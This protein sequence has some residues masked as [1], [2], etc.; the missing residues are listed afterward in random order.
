MTEDEDQEESSELA[1]I[2]STELIAEIKRERA[3]P[4]SVYPKVFGIAA[5]T[6]DA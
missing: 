2:Y 6:D 3:N 5:W 4:N 1:K